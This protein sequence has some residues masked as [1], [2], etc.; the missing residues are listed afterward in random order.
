MLGRRCRQ[1]GGV[2]TFLWHNSSFRGSYRHAAH[3]YEPAIAEMS[4]WRT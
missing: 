1:V 2:M 4:G 3:I